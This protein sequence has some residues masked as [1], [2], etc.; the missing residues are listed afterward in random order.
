MMCCDIC[1]LH[2]GDFRYTPCMK[3]FSCLRDL[4]PRDLTAIYLD[5][6][7]NMPNMRFPPQV[8]MSGFVVIFF[9]HLFCFRRK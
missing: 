9:N 8:C 2:V 7:F 4:K 6:T 1:R 3:E 5:T